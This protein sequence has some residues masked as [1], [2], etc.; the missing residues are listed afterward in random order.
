MMSVVLPA[1]TG[2]TARIGLAG[3]VSARASVIATPNPSVD[4]NIQWW[5]FMMASSD[6]W[7]DAKAA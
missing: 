1:P 7:S 3:H 6:W 4:S 5:G 2:M